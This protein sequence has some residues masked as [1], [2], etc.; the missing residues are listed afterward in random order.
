MGTTISSYLVYIQVSVFLFGVNRG[1]N[2]SVPAP[3]FARRGDAGGER[4]G[5]DSVL[6][7]Y[8]LF[9]DAARVFQKR[10]G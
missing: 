6:D 3:K 7:N 5:A 8:L 4:D 9:G 1:P 10:G 2:R